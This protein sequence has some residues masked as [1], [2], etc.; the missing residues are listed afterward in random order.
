MD[1]FADLASVVRD[2]AVVPDH[3]D[4][5]SYDP[6]PANQSPSASVAAAPPYTVIEPIQ[7]Q[8]PLVFASP[9]SGRIYPAHF[10]SLAR[11]GL[12]SLRRSEDAYV[13]QL[14]ARAV[15][16]GGALISA[17]IARAYIDLNRDPAELDPGMYRDAIQAPAASARVQAGLGAIPRIAGDGA[18]I[19]RGKLSATVAQERID[20][21]HKPYHAR[22]RSLLERKKQEFGCAVLIDC[23][24]MPSAARGPHAPDIV[25]GDRYGAA[26]HASVTALAEAMLRRR[27]YRVARNAPFA[28]GHTT[29]MYGRPRERTHA[30]QIEIN[31]ALYLE[32]ATLAPHTGF[33]R[34]AAD[35]TCLAEALAAAEFH[36]S[37]A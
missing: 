8:A 33:A 9:H 28:G 37:L 24:S 1:T 2:D 32:E 3:N 29:Q 15:H 21:V 19:Y 31:R 18:P 4:V 10:L 23:H 30:L 11:A 36:K 25:L 7:G 26:C 14:F 34:V 16:S 5:Q 13:D 20:A 27:G 6:A 35:M 17:T 22:L 12:A